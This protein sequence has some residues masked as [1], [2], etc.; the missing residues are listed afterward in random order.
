LTPFCRQINLSDKEQTLPAVPVPDLHLRCWTDALP[1]TASSSRKNS[2]APR[3]ISLYITSEK[4]LKSLYHKKI[5]V[6]MQMRKEFD[7]T[8]GIVYN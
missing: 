8:A 4:I 7:E 5:F 1:V 6:T 3:M 2:I